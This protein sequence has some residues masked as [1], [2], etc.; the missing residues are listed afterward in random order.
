MSRFMCRAAAFIACL[1]L[2]TVAAS[3]DAAKE[4]YEKGKASFSKGDYDL[5]ISAFSEAIRLNP[6]HAGA[7]YYRSLAYSGKG[8]YDKAIADANEAIRLAPND[9]AA[10]YC[11]GIVYRHKGEHDRSIADYD[12]ASAQ[13]EI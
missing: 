11:R 2:P 6:R 10:Y 7:Y 1:L 8:E 9:A 13:P 12:E 3:A 5:A 4:A